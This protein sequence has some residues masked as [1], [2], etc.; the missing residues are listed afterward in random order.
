MKWIGQYIWDKISRFRNEVYLE[1]IETGTIASG[2]S[3]GLDSNNK[4]VKASASSGGIAFDGSTANG[5]LT[6]KDSDEATVE[7]NLTFDGSTLSLT[8]DLT[9]EGDTITLQ[10]DNADD[11]KIVI[12]NNTNDTQ[13]ARLQMKKNRGAAQVNNDNVA[14]MDFFGED[15]GQNQAQYAKMLVRANEVTDG[16]ESGDFRIQ[17]AAHDASLTQGLKLVGGS[18]SGEVDVTVGAGTA[19][20][21]TIAGTL[22][23]GSTAFVDNSGVVQVATQGTIDHDSLANFVANEHIDWTGS[24]AGTVHSSNIPTLNQDTTGVAA[25]LTASTSNS[26]GVGSIELGHANDTTIARSASG[27][28]TIEGKIA[29]TR[30]K[31]IYMETSNFSDDINTD[32]HYIPFVSTS[33][34]TNFA[35]VAVP[36]LA[37]VAGKLLGVHFKANVH[38]NTS[39]NTVTFRLAKCA[40]GELWN[41]SNVTVLGTKVVDGVARE[42]TC[43]ADFQDL[44]TSGASGTNAFAANELIGV[45][46]QNSQNLASTKYSVTLVFEFDY[47]SY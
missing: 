13:G 39:S 9:V 36:M 40:D 7:S 11:P 22:T 24:S 21:T 5:V 28:A 10:S 33:E 31:V 37:P 29:Q 19:S 46:M 14:E 35:N 34:H 20:V 18:Q 43:S 44:T 23:M 25:G 42:N 1:S 45:S 26:I 2:G 6:Y 3:L 27:V 12:Q 16:Q 8:G 41:S 30:D 4:V 47:N 17:V 32:A 38:T 15:A